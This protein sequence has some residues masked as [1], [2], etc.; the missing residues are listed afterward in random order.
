[1]FSCFCLQLRKV[2]LAFGCGEDLDLAP[3]K[4]PKVAPRLDRGRHPGS[5]RQTTFDVR[6][7]I[8]PSPIRRLP[9]SCSPGSSKVMVARS[10]VIVSD[11]AGGAAAAAVDLVGLAAGVRKASELSPRVGTMAAFSVGPA[12]G[13][14]E[15]PLRVPHPVTT[16]P[17]SKAGAT[18]AMRRRGIERSP[19][20]ENR[21]R[22]A[23]RQTSD[24]GN[25]K[26]VV[27]ETQ[28]K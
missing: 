26:R 27:Q 14:S 13:F 25:P 2:G 17:A 12:R 18:P 3:L 22:R 8:V 24:Q 4:R 21:G 10:G 11:R 7:R 20:A 28:G 15:D 6:S 23:S 16:N 1:M 5:T 19:L 9:S